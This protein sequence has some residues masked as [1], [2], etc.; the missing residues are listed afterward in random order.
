MFLDRRQNAHFVVHHHIVLR[1]IL[2]L[3]IFQFL[4]LMDIDQ[5][6]PFEAFIEAARSTLRG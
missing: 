2:R 4:F 1:W 3:H 5:D 6:V